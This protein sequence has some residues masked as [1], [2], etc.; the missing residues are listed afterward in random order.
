MKL[1]TWKWPIHMAKEHTGMVRKHKA[2]WHSRVIQRSLGRWRILGISA[3]A[4]ATLAATAAYAFV[5]TDAAFY[6]AQDYSPP[7]AAGRNPGDIA[8]FESGPADR[9]YRNIG[10]FVAM[11]RAFNLLSSAPTRED[12]KEALRAKAAAMG[13]DAVIGVRYRSETA[14][15]ASRGLMIG[16]GS[17][18]TWKR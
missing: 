18:I 17:A 4:G 12:V 6:P 9:P 2:G 8:I 16:E 7:A 14:G 5:W 10:G 3:L 1:F 13:A 11:A 15:F